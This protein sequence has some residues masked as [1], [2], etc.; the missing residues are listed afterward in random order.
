[1]YYTINTLLPSDSKKIELLLKKHDCKI[2]KNNTH[3]KVIVPDSNRYSFPPRLRSKLFLNSN[4]SKNRFEVFVFKNLFSWLESVYLIPEIK[5]LF[6][7]FGD[8]LVSK[9]PFIKNVLNFDSDLDMNVFNI[10]YQIITQ[11]LKRKNKLQ[12]FILVNHHFISHFPFY[13]TNGR[14][15]EGGNA[16]VPPSIKGRLKDHFHSD[17]LNGFLHLVKKHRKLT[18]EKAVDDLVFNYKTSK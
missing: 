5:K 15:L 10:R 11:F 16:Q 14:F 17:Y 2:F 3:N 12:N 4:P 8:F 13:F 1:M 7:N 9:N 6:P 18:L